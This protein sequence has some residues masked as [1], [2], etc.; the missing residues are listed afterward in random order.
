MKISQKPISIVG[1]EAQDKT[2]DGNN[3]VKLVGGKIEGKVGNDDVSFLVP[4]T[5]VS[6]GSK[7]GIHRV[8]I[9]GIK[10][11]GHDANNY[12]LEKVND[13]TV[14]ISEDPTT[15][16]EIIIPDKELPKTGVSF[17]IVIMIFI[18]FILSTIIRKKYKNINK[19]MKKR[20]QNE[21]N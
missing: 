2:Y 18:L 17:A 14:K 21:Q 1:L 19:Q 3:I 20:N 11:E 12:K 5:V 13:V 4:D 8:I 15:K 10:L 9:K 16:K 6:E 7:V